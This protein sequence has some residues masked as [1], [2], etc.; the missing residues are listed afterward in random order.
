[1][2]PL[3]LVATP[4]ASPRWML[5]GSFSRSAFASYAM[6]GTELCANTDTQSPS[7]PAITSDRR[8]DRKGRQDR[9]E[10]SFMSRLLPT[11]LAYSPYLPRPPY[12]ARLLDVG[13]CGFKTIFCTRQSV[14]S[15]T[16]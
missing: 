16:N 15:D 2:W 5:S 6:S 12:F 3:E 11:C 10:R 9:K 1:M 14:I 8:Q 7:A 4:A 13:V